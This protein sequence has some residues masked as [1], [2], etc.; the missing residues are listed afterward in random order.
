MKTKLIFIRHGFSESNKDGLFTG[1][2]NVALTELG[3]L[4]AQLSAKYLEDVHIDAVYSSTLSRAFDTAKPVAESRGLEITQLHGLCEIDS[5][6]WEEKSFEALG[7]LFP[8]EY[9]MWMTDIFKC[10]C[11]NGESVA[12]FSKRV[13]STVVQIA[14]ENPG[15]TVCIATHATPIRVISC[16]AL[17]LTPA[18]LKDV[19]W[20]PNASINIID[21]EDGSFSFSQRDIT[22]HLKGYETNLPSNV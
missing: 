19:P 15:K 12:E 22:R 21:Y 10:Q 7:T 5:G 20:S 16:F 9:K 18:S 11:P 8:T 13:H 17:G 2:A 4:Q 3:Q 14:E 6:D 1:Q